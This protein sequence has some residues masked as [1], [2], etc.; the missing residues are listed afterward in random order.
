MI[1][2]WISALRPKASRIPDAGK[3]R[4]AQASS[5]GRR[6][7]DAEQDVFRRP[8]ASVNVPPRLSSLGRMNTLA[9]WGEQL[10]RALLQRTPAPPLGARPGRRRPGTRPGT[11]PRHGRRPA[12]SRR[13][14][15][16]HRLRPRPRRHRPAPARRRPVPA[17]RPA[18]RRPAVPAGRPPLL[19]HHRSRRTRTRRHPELRVR[20]CTGRAGQRADL[21]RHDHQPGRPARAG[22]AGGS[23]R[24]TTATAPGTW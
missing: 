2:V 21:L 12:G 15:A 5:A 8:A 9:P 23:P 7:P 14:A 1:P 10:A 19:R 22:R 18:R 6:G 20:P 13:L 11:C 4:L 16:R 24:Y 3:V 17:R